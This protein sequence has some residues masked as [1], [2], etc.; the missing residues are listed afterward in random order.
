MN[1]KIRSP[2]IERACVVGL[3]QVGL[4]TATYISNKGLIVCGYD[5]NEQSIVKAKSLGI[6][7]TATWSEVPIV[8]V[9]VICVSSL[10]KINEPDLSAVFDVCRKI[11]A[12]MD[13]STLVSIESTIIPGVCRRIYEDIFRR[14]G[15]IVHVPHRYWAGDPIKH[16]VNQLRVFGAID[17]KSMKKG[18]EFYRDQL[19]IPLHIVSSIE[20]AEMSKVTEN[21]YRYVQIAFAEE[22]RM[23]CDGL[24]IDFEEVKESCNTK[25][26]IEI[27]DAKGGIGGHCLPKD[28]G[29]YLS[30]AKDANSLLKGAIETDEKYRERIKSWERRVAVR[31]LSDSPYE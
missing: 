10:L 20:V 9:Y 16:G 19:E 1:Q 24:G 7:A 30:L 23:I 2:N 15:L 29:Y 6:E 18:L 8:D 4:P 5:I 26:N 14:Q 11:V 28:V 12:K 22:L 31:A 17:E 25:W 13:D 27:L 21:A 3:G